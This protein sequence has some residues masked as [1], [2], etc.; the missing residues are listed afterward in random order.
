MQANRFGRVLPLRDCVPPAIMATIICRGLAFGYDGTESDVFKDLELVI[1]TGWRAALAGRNGRGKT[2]LLR[3]IHGD[4]V[5]DR[6]TIERSAATS[7]FPPPMDGPTLPARQAVK[8]AIAPYRRWEAE[9]E[10]LLVDGGDMALARY[11]DLLA[12]YQEAGGYA[13][14]ARIETELAALDIA[15]ELWR[16]PFSSLSGGEQTRCLLAGLFAQPHGYALIDEPTNHLDGEGRR[17]LARY[18]RTKAGFLLVSHDRAFLDT[19][20]DHVVA[21]NP[22]TVE[23]QRTSFSA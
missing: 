21:L 17:L 1:D 10:S 3:L 19:C 20:C 9:M 13:I 5:P 2:T 22:D 14:D 7:Y 16:R 18:L 6:G 12:A 11:G 23:V 4:L 15:E 8:D